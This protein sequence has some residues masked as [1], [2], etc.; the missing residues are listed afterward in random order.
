MIFGLLFGN[1]VIFGYIIGIIL[2]VSIKL[3][4]CIISGNALINAKLFLE[5]FF[6]III[7]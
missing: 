4:H 1:D 5:S 6:I 2:F 7:I 3:I